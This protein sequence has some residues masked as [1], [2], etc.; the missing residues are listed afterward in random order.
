[1]D[2]VKTIPY[3]WALDLECTLGLNIQSLKIY[4]EN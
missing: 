3:E 4:F 2:V 1:M